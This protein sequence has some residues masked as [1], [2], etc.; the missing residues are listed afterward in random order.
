[1]TDTEAHLWAK[2]ASQ[3]KLSFSSVGG[4]QQ[5]ESGDRQPPLGPQEPRVHERQ[6]FETQTFP[7]SA[8]YNSGGFT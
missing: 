8:G 1:M 3:N 4:Q 6:V 5:R 2:N 7:D